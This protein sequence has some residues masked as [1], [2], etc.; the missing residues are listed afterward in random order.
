MYKRQDLDDV[1]IPVFVFFGWLLGWLPLLLSTAFVD[2]PEGISY[3]I[4]V[5]L[6]LPFLL[7]LEG[8]GGAG[9]SKLCECGK[10]SGIRNRWI[11]SKVKY[12]N[13]W[14]GF[15]AFLIAFALSILSLTV[16]WTGVNLAGPNPHQIVLWIIG[17]VHFAIFLTSAITTYGIPSRWSKQLYRVERLKTKYG[18]YFKRKQPA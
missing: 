12:A 13:I 1:V 6:L 5:P 4:I 14:A 15:H 18:K 10:Y 9:M 17:A 8:G 16:V 2:Y 7:M 3:M 11:E